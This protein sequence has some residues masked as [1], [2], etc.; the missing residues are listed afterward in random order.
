MGVAVVMAKLELARP[1]REV[2]AVLFCKSCPAVALQCGLG[3]DV[4]PLGGDRW[5][6]LAFVAL[7]FYSWHRDP[8]A[9]GGP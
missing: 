9:P 5:N 2:L 3:S 8:V 4:L 6:S 1:S 7:G